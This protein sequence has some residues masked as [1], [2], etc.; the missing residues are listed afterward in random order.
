[1]EN[2]RDRLTKEQAL[3]TGNNKDIIDYILWENGIN[4]ETL[5]SE[6][7]RNFTINLYHKLFVKQK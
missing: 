5:T 3:S 6:E 2:Q 4:P 7:Y 1:M